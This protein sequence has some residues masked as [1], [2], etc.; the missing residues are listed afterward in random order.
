MGKINL[1]KQ[2]QYVEFAEKDSESRN[3]AEELDKSVKQD[4]DGNVD[5]TGDLDVAGDLAV[6]GS[7]TT[8]AGVDTPS[9]NTSG[10]EISAQKPVVE[11]MNGY[12][13]G[14]EG[15][16]NLTLSTIYVGAVKNGNKLTLVAFLTITRTGD[17][18]DDWANLG[19]FDIPAAIANKIIPY[20]GAKVAINKIWLNDSISLF[21]ETYKN[22]ATRLTYSTSG[23][24]STLN[25]NSTYP[26]RIEQTYLLS[27]SIAD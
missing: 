4:A 20:T 13:F 1:A 5:I 14:L 11:V 18:V 19:H 10:T 17:V 26:C 25:L 2:N 23:L 8:A 24:N 9:L 3:I 27:D 6:T 12:S 16:A 22:S 21:V 7:I 15:K